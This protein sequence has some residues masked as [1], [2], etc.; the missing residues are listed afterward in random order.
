ML[1]EKEI[2]ALTV[3]IRTLGDCWYR[4]VLQGLLDRSKGS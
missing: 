3:V 1:T 4:D 2:E